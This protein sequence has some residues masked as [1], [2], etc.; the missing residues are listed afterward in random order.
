MN[1]L[2]RW[3]EAHALRDRADNEVRRRDAARG[4]YYA[5]YHMLCTRFQISAN[6]KGGNHTRLFYA[7][8]QHSPKVAAQFLS[9]KFLREHADYNHDVE[10]S[11][12][13]MDKAFQH[14]SAVLAMLK[15]DVDVPASTAPALPGGP[16]RVVPIRGT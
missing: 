2:D 15:I 12:V 8:K 7:V 14:T 11:S 3:T 4:I 13:E 5:V 6:D 1:A 10:F 9:L 16:A